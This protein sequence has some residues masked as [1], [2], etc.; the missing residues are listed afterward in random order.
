[1][2]LAQRNWTSIDHWMSTLEER[3]SLHDPFQYEDELTYITQVRVFLAQN[4]PGEAIH[5]LSCLEGYAQSSGRQGRLIEILLLKAL[6]LQALGDSVQADIAFTKSLA[7]AEP[8]DYVR[9]F[10]EEGKPIL[11]LLKRLNLSEL[12]PKLRD[13]ISRL[14]MAGTSK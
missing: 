8:S 2:W 14:I 5:L 10:V 6:A 7:L 3:F 12:T 1:M 9:I 13:Y 11:R 4:K